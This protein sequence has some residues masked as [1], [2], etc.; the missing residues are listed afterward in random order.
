MQGETEFVTSHRFLDYIRLLFAKQPV[1]DCR[2]RFLVLHETGRAPILA[3][4]LPF[5]AG[6]PTEYS[7]STPCR[8][9]RATPNLARIFHQSSNDSTLVM[10]YG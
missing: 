3:L 9:L 1:A 4:R 7:R 10:S 5:A 8:S 6:C 2:M